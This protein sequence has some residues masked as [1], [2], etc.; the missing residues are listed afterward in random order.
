[1]QTYIEINVPLRQDA[2][3]MTAL[4]RKLSGTLVRWQKGGYHITVAFMNKTSLA[5][6]LITALNN[7]ISGVK[8]PPLQF[9][10]V[11]AFTAINTGAHIIHLTASEIPEEFS[12]WV[13]MARRVLSDNGC[14]IETDFRLHVTLGRIQEDAINLD[15]LKIAL[16]EVEMPSFSIQLH[17]VTFCIFRGEIIKTWRW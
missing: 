6:S 9:D 17:E 10:K 3:W 4:R 2:A 13:N 16:K 12:E 1:M 15:S 8:L 5:P 11:D 14:E 7:C